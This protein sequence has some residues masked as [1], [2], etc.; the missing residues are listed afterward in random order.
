VNSIDWAARQDKL[1]SLTPKPA[2]SRFVLPP[3]SQAIGGIFLITVILIPAAVLA[4]GVYVWWSRR[5]RG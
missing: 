3:T 2:I 4:A 1:I 5:Q